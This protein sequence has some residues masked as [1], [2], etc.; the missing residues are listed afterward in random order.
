MFTLC[1]NVNNINDVAFGFCCR[2]AVN[3]SIM[4]RSSIT[5][6]YHT[7]KRI[8]TQNVDHFVLA[9]PSQLPV[10]ALQPCSENSIRSILSAPSAWNNSTKAH[11]KNKTISHT[12]TN[13]S[14]NCSARANHVRS[15]QQ[16]RR[17]WWRPQQSR[18]R[19]HI[20]KS[21]QTNKTSQFQNEKS[22]Y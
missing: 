11:S 14:T 15:H 10:V 3:R 5:K 9:A 18:K 4:D 21:H 1:E 17:R 12:V 20:K 6:G 13:A 8:I 16:Q 2:I 19:K 7:V 22:F